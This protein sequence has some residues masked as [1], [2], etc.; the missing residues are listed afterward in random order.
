M[1]LVVPAARPERM[2][3]AD[4]IVP[5]ATLLLLHV[6]P[7]AVSLREVL[8]PAQTEAMPEMAEGNGSTVSIVVLKQPAANW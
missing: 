1:I 8:A 4:P 2:P 5:T 3:D 6:P 7:V